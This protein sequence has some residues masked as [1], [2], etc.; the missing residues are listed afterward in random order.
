MRSQVLI[1]GVAI[2]DIFSILV[3][4]LTFLYCL[5]LFHRK[6]HLHKHTELCIH[7]HVNYEIKNENDYISGA[8]TG[9]CSLLV[10]LE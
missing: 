3:L 4:D 6:I 10:V 1:P 9:V 8:G 5:K 7:V 2:S